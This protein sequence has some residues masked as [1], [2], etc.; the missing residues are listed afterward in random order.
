MKLDALHLDPF[1]WEETHPFERLSHRWRLANGS[2][3]PRRS[4][5][6]FGGRLLLTGLTGLRK[7]PD[8]RCCR[9]PSC[10]CLC[11]GDRRLCAYDVC[12]FDVTPPF[13]TRPGNTTIVMDQRTIYVGNVTSTVDES[14]MRS[15]FDNCG[16]VTSV[17]IAGWAMDASACPR[18]TCPQ[19]LPWTSVTAPQ[20]LMP[21]CA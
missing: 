12:G 9:T 3:Q 1:R 21:G 8:Q 2:R 15:V 4:L 19:P 7:L 11:R 14:A 6:D 18:D 13:S 10:S 17:R 16:T 20:C 5:A